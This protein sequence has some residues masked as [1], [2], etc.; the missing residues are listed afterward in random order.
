MELSNFKAFAVSSD[1]SQFLDRIKLAS[2][3]GGSEEGV[4]MDQ[5]MLFD[6]AA[7]VL[8]NVCDTFLSGSHLR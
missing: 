2:V 3:T 8:L 4:E 1:S 5:R 7:H 6:A